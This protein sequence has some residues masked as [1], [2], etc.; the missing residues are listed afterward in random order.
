MRRISRRTYLSVVGSG[1]SVTAASSTAAAADSESGSTDLSYGVGG[2]GA[3]GY[4]HPTTDDADNGDD[5]EPDTDPDP[6][7]PRIGYVLLRDT[8]PPNPHVDLTVEWLVSHEQGTLRD[9]QIIV[10]TIDRTVVD[11]SVLVIDGT[12]ATGSD[13]FRIKHGAG[14]TYAVTLRVTDTSGAMVSQD[15]QIA[16]HR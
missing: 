11:D 9:V 7:P 15:A 10:Q 16:T 3:G 6:S 14:E 1:V 8:S 5:E 2:Y 4:G 12:E 13:S